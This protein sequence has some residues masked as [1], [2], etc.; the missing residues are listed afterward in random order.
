MI[1]YYDMTWANTFADGTVK[2]LWFILNS[3]R[4]TPLRA[5]G[6][7]LFILAGIWLWRRKR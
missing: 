7:G 5:A 4:D 6:V 3:T 1:L 2:M